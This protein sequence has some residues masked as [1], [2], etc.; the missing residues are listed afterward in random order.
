MTGNIYLQSD[1]ISIYD[2]V[3]N[4]LKSIEES[5]TCVGC[6][7]YVIEDGT[8]FR[9]VVIGT[10]KELYDFMQVAF[11]GLSGMLW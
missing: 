9:V 1:S 3:E 2:V 5:A 10:K 8:Y 11:Y 7:P 6:I 4:D